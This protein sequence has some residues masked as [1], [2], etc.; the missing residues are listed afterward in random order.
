MSDNAEKTQ[1]TEAEATET[2]EAQDGGEAQ[3]STSQATESKATGNAMLDAL[4]DGEGV[5]FDFSKGERPDGF[6]EDYWNTENNT[7][8]VQK[9]Y[10][11]LKKQEKIATDLR[12]KMGKGDHKAP[13]DAS[14]YK[15]ELSEKTASLIPADDPLLKSARETAHKYGM[16]QE[17][18]NGFISE[19]TDKMVDISENSQKE[20]SP[21]EAKAYAQEQ[22][23]KIGPNGA[24]VLRAVNSFGKE[25]LDTGVFSASDYKTFQEQ[26][27]TSPEMVVMFNR[28]RA[29]LSSGTDGIP[30][31]NFDDGLPSDSVIADMVDKAYTAKDEA[32]I[33][34]VEELLDQ[35]RK[36]GRPEKLQF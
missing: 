32:Q 33:R 4:E 30:H 23:A 31:D 22:I 14:E 12:R 10:E 1:S 9:L 29:R 18:F 5:T 20:L 19:I 7:P 35:R 2:V 36:A 16:S 3:D 34:K 26:G 6:P 8:D 24:Q 11:G 15:V 28:L 25:L 27:L 21:E 17:M 13:K